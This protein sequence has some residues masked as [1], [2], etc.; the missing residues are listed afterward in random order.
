MGKN[1]VVCKKYPQLFE[2]CD[3]QT[4]PP[5]SAVGGTPP[6]FEGLHGRSRSRQINAAPHIKILLRTAIFMKPETIFKIYIVVNPE[7]IGEQFLPDI[8]V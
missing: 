4:P 7:N 2:N 6:F 1:R 5:E 3:R 8:G